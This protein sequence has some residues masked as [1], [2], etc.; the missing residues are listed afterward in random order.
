MGEDVRS[1][2]VHML[3]CSAAELSIG[4]MYEAAVLE[5]L[6]SDFILRNV[7]GAMSYQGKSVVT[8][9]KREKQLKV[10]RA[11]VL[12]RVFAPLGDAPLGGA[13]LVPKGCRD[14]CENFKK[15][16]VISCAF[17]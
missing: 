7:T 5:H 4:S 16:Y 1:A 3:C 12:N 14:T 6:V 2:A 11:G 15:I 9:T 10:S 17:Y 13:S 8:Q